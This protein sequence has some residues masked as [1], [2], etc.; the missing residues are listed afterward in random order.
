[1]PKPSSRLLA[2]T[3]VK[4]LITEASP[5]N[6]PENASFDEENFE[7]NRDGSRNRR[8]GMDYEAGHVDIA[9][10]LSLSDFAVA[11]PLTY[12][13]TEIGGNGLDNFAVV[14]TG[15]QLFFFDINTEPLSSSGYR[16]TLTLA[17]YPTNVRYSLTSVDGYL[18]VAAGV[19][20]F[21][22][23]TYNN[24]GFSVEYQRIAVRDVWGIET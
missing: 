13:W 24:P 1:M 11:V 5:L 3:F 14:Q 10:S 15:N 19:D 9:T 21:A 23:I 8:K 17:G 18:V 2:N 20:T 6:F 4:G 16:G 22:V 12:K 7:L